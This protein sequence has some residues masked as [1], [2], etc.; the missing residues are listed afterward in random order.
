M[1]V[2][3][4]GEI[5]D[6]VHAFGRNDFARYLPSVQQPESWKAASSYTYTFPIV[7]SMSR[8]VPGKMLVQKKEERY[9]T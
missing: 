1:V 4:G 8:S 5:D 9:K 6:G 2:D 3:D 7:A